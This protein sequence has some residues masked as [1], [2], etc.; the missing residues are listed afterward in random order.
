MKA[1]KKE[2]DCIELS[3]EI[4]VLACDR[5]IHEIKKDL[6]PIIL[7]P[8]GFLNKF[9]ADFA[10]IIKHNSFGKNAIFILL[11]TIF[12]IIIIPISFFLSIYSFIKG[13]NQRIKKNIIKV[14]SLSYMDYE[15]SD[16]KLFVQ[17]WYDKGL[18]EKSIDKFRL[19]FTR[20]EKHKCIEGWFRILYGDTSKLN[21][22]RETIL[23][24][25]RETVKSFYEENPKGHINMQ[26]IENIIPDEVDYV[27]P[28]Y[29]P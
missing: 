14:M 18:T 27:M 20:E 16:H 28:K 2:I 26:A 13:N 24:R 22:M 5:L 6:I 11:L 12:Y 25:Q 23:A 15:V 4:H 19:T 1:S 10:K 17:L 21:V 29:S 3:R 9:V 7:T 8:R